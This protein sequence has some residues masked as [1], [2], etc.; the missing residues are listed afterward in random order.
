MIDRAFFFLFF[1]YFSQ[2]GLFRSLQR[3]C[4]ILKLF[5]LLPSQ[6]YDCFFFSFILLN[7]FF[8]RTLRTSFESFGFEYL[9]D[10]RLRERDS[11][12]TYPDDFL[13]VYL[14]VVYKNDARSYLFLL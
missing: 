12:I 2:S 10:K 11:E 3:F 8:V 14:F 5:L 6:L 7:P 4:L 1:K 9:V 13:G